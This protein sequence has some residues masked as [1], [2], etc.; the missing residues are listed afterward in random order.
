MK[1]NRVFITNPIRIAIL[2]LI[3]TFS[4]V[5]TTR[6]SV[7]GNQSTSE[8]R[9]FVDTSNILLSDYAK[10]NVPESINLVDDLLPSVVEIP[11]SEI[12]DE[13]V[14]P[15]RVVIVP[16][17]SKN[18][19]IVYRKYVA[20]EITINLREVLESLQHQS[21]SQN[22]E[23]SPLSQPLMGTGT[24]NPYF[25]SVNPALWGHCDSGVNYSY[26]TVPTNSTSFVANSSL[27][28]WVPG[29]G[30]ASSW[31][32]AYA[33]GNNYTTLCIPK[34][35]YWQYIEPVYIANWWAGLA[36][37]IAYQSTGNWT[38]TWHN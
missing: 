6:A 26:T 12:P 11:L 37:H 32:F 36:L 25:V 34:T 16:E 7:A 10:E 29:D 20:P 3:V 30:S 21:Q 23:N 14:L 19:E 18:G 9:L 22:L 2:A 24:L 27:P 8:G 35:L 13:I 1:I 38:T 33:S 28:T 31:N 17:E 4:L 15:K 5:V